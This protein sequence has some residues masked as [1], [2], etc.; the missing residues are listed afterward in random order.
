MFA[1]CNKTFWFILIAWNITLV[2]IGE[3]SQV[4]RIQNQTDNVSPASSK[5]AD[6]FQQG[7]TAENAKMIHTASYVQH[8]T[9]WF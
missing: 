7:C 6:V 8:L 3:L 2:K 9:L 4:K 1:P 5:H